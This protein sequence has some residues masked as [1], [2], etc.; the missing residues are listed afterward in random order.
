MSVSHTGIGAAPGRSAG[1]AHV[2][3]ADSTVTSAPDGSIL[4]LRVFHP[5]FAP[6]MRRIRGIVVEQGGMLQHAVILAREFGIPA[7]VGLSKATE[8][9]NT[10]DYLEIDG[11][12]GTVISTTPGPRSPA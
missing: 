3:A 1:P 5:Y 4:V 11:G 8:V 12:T 2:A 10:G 6:L 9:I 7:I